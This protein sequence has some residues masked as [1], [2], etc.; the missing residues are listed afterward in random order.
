MANEQSKRL[1]ELCGNHIV[2][3]FDKLLDLEREGINHGIEIDKDLLQL[4]HDSYLCIGDVAGVGGLNEYLGEIDIELNVNKDSF[5]QGYVNVL[6]SWWVNESRL[7][8]LDSFAEENNVN[9][10]Y[11]KVLQEA[12]NKKLVTFR[13]KNLDLIEEKSKSEGI[14]LDFD[15]E[16]FVEG[17][18]KPNSRHYYSVT[19]YREFEAF[20]TRKGVTLDTTN[21]LQRDYRDALGNSREFIIEDIEEI[22]EEKGVELEVDEDFLKRTL[23]KNYNENVEKGDDYCAKELMKYAKSKGVR[24]EEHEK[25]NEQMGD[26]FSISKTVGEID[27]EL[28]GGEMNIR[29]FILGKSGGRL[30][31]IYDGNCGYHRYIGYKH[32]ISPIGGGY[33]NVDLQENI[34]EVFSSSGDFDY[35]P[36]V[37][38]ANAL[39]L[40]FPDFKIE[41]RK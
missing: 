14:N 23:Q 1:E 34:I 41:V 37:V 27:I 40:A 33:M 15:P 35:E 7:E 17:F 25:Q 24:L 9:I 39:S 3:G 26:E 4:V 8:T 5:H 30:N 12:Y 28:T 2:L 18:S 16:L 10:D 31:V 22:A 11:K 13:L 29:K 20:A 19:S 36:R 21:I 6:T 32:G 38:T